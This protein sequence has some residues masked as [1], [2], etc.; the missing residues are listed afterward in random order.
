[1]KRANRI[2]SLLLAIVMIAGLLP[3]MSLS[4][5]AAFNDPTLKFDENGKFTIMQL[6]DIHLVRVDGFGPEQ[7]TL[8]VIRDL[9][10]MM[11][12]SSSPAYRSSSDRR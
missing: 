3:A 11:P 5:S 4:S 6:T 2:L 7:R 9:I 1:M 12:G 8:D 10:D